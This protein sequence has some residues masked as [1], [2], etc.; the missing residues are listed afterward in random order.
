MR[1]TN[2]TDVIAYFGGG[3]KKLAAERAGFTR[4]TIYDW[5]RAGV[6]PDESAAVLH[7]KSGGALA[8]PE[9]FPL[10]QPVSNECT[11]CL[12]PDHRHG[13]RRGE[14]RRFAVDRRH[15]ERRDDVERRADE[16]ADEEDAA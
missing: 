12:R 9:G 10:V 5:L 14:E 1:S 3:N 8:P 4:K 2:P 16:P 11:Q 15:L 6:V 7:L 13:E